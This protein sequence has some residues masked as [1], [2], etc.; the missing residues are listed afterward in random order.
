[1]EIANR[2]INEGKTA[3]QIA[4]SF[5]GRGIALPVS[6]VYSIL[7]RLRDTGQVK[8]S[9]HRHRTPLYTPEELRYV[10]ELQEQHNEWSYSRLRQAWQERY[11]K[12][13]RLSN[14]MIYKALTTNHITTKMLQEDPEARDDL[15]TIEMRKEYCREAVNWSR[16]SVIFIDE[17]GFHRQQHRNRGRSRRGRPATIRIPN[18]KGYRINVCAAV[19]PCYGL[20]YYEPVAGQTWDAERFRG[21]MHNLIHNNL[22]TQHRSFY[23]VMDNVSF[24][25][26]DIVTEVLSGARIPHEIKLLPR[27]SP[28][29]NVIEYCFNRWKARVKAND[30]LHETRSLLE[31]IEQAAVLITPQ[32]VNRCMDHVM[33][34][35]L[36]CIE[37]KP[38]GK[39][40]PLREDGIPKAVLDREERKVQ[41]EDEVKE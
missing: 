35:Y 28:H 39:F 34:V 6:T 37:G 22:L 41:E 20:V 40:I 1:M 27:Y 10:A 8:L 15:T 9:H 3:K 30:Q 17:I 19:S 5:R 36:H 26:S 7:H 24:H 14:Y 12:G 18:S 31:Q 21:F 23:F 16:E 29:L 2:F 33:Q 25:K 38:L 13:R 4:D 11:G 32:Y